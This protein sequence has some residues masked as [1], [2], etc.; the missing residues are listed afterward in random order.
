[1]FRIAVE[2]DDRASERLDELAGEELDDARRQLVDDSMTTVLESVVRLNPVETGRA[3]S[4]WVR[5]LR[6]AGGEAPAGWRGSRSRSGAVAEGASLGGL[7][8]SAGRSRDEVSA[9]NSVS[10]IRYLEYGTSKMQAF[11]M[12]RRSI[13]QA[14][15]RLREV[16]SFPPE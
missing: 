11:A 9:T 10:Y 4:A 8:R 7:S 13:A 12:V 6:E 16:F 1:M 3:R 5:A 14:V 15:P 2:I